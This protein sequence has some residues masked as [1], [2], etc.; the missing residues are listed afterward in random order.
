[1]SSFRRYLDGRARALAQD[2]EV[3]AF[4][5]LPHVPDPVAHPAF[6]DIFGGAWVVRRGT[7]V[8]RD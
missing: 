4:F 2:G 5:A 1:M 3:V 8:S 6:E 7:F